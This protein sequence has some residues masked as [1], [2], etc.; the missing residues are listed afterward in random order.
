MDK[1]HLNQAL[2]DLGHNKDF[3]L[4]MEWFGDERNQIIEQ[5]S[6][7]QPSERLKWLSGHLNRMTL[8]IEY[9]KKAQKR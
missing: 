9:I 8:I 1:K 2:I 7:E 3:Q 4:V 6:G 5:L